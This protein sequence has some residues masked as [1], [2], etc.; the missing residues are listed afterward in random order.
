[1]SIIRIIKRTRDSELITEQRARKIGSNKK[2]EKIDGRVE[3]KI[4]VR[5][6]V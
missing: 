2:D 5:R 6:N 3:L 4:K 1:M